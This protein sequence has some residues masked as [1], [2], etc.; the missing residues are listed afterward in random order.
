[1]CGGMGTCV[2]VS[3]G[4]DQRRA[5]DPLAWSYSV[6][7]Q[8]LWMHGSELYPLQEHQVFLATDHPQKTVYF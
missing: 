1:M 7:E 5:L 6:P 4:R 2:Q 3:V 8:Q